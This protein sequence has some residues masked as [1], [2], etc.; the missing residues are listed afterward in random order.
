M[1]KIVEGNLLDAKENI[2]GHQVNCQ[3]VMGSGVAKQ[4]RAKYPVVFRR[5]V[6]HCNTMPADKLLGDLQVIKLGAEKY[7]A[8]IFGQ[9][10]YGRN[11]DVQYT[12]YNALTESI[13]KLKNQAKTHN[14][15]VALPYLI[16]CGFGN[17]DWDN[18]VLP[19]LECVFSDYELTLYKYGG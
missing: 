14:M 19:M 5:Y 10:T 15:S 1:I 3:G 9:L 7:V 17:G 2:I 13:I 11:K 12:N 16:G 8:N 4:I 18:E 6:D